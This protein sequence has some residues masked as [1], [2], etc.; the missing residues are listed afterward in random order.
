M[1][2]SK[3]IAMATDLLAAGRAEDV[4]RMVDPLLEPIASP[5]SADPGQVMLHALMARVHL[6]HR[7]NAEAALELLDPFDTPDVRSRLG[8]MARAEVTLWLGWAHAMRNLAGDRRAHEDAQAL[9]LLD[10]AEELFAG[11][12]SPSGRCWALLGKARAYF[13][14]D[15]YHLMRRVLAEAESVHAKT[16]DAQAARWLHDLSVPALRFQG[17]YDDAQS[18]VDALFDLADDWNDQRVRGH[19]YA[20]QAALCYDLGRNPSSIREAASTAETLLR[21]LDGGSDYPLLAAFHAHVGALLR[22]G[23][24]SEA[25]SLLDEAGDAVDSYPVGRAHLQTLRARLAMRRNDLDAAEALMEDLFDHAH[26]LPHG[27]Q[28]SHVALLRGE[29]LARREHYEEAQTWIQRASRNARE[30]GHRGN[31]LRTLLALAQTAVHRGDLSAADALLTQTE[32][33]A[34]YYSVLPH[35]LRRFS[36]IGDLACADDRLDDA[37]S[38]YEQALSAASLVGDAYRA[39]QLQRT[40]G[41]LGAATR[42]EDALLD[43]AASTFEHLGADPELSATRAVVREHAPSYQAGTSTAFEDAIGAALSRA[44]TSVEL[45]AEAWIQGVEMLAPDRW[46]G[47]YRAN[48]PPSRP[49]PD[50]DAAQHSA[51]ASWTCVHEHGPAPEDLSFPNPSDAQTHTGSVQWIRLRAHSTERFFLG[52]AVDD[53]DDA[54]WTE[55]LRR[56]RPWIPVVRLAFDR[57]LHR[58]KRAPAALPRPDVEA[59]IPLDGFVSESPAMAALAR[60]IRR[61]HMSHSPVLITGESGTGKTLVGRA[62]HVTSERSA[63]PFRHVRCTNMQQ[64]PIE[65][66]LFG[67]VAED[68]SLVP[69]AFHEADGGT[70]LL[71]DVGD[72]PQPVQAS[73]LRALDSHEIVPQGA[74]DAQP[75]DVRVLATTSQDLKQQAQTGAFRE[76]LYYRLA[77]IPLRVPPLR[78]RREDLPLLVRHFLRTLGP[79]DMP[80]AS[81]TNRALDV[82][83]HYDWPG[84]VRQLRNEI[85][86][87]LVFV[88]SEP[89]PTIDADLLSDSIVRESSSPQAGTAPR[90]SMNADDE[91]DTIFQSDRSLSDVLADTE[92]RIIERVLRDCNGQ[93]TASAEVLGL[94]RQGL[95]KKMKRLDIDAS[96]FQ[97][98]EEPAMT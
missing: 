51:D 39:A 67:R 64:E 82:L 3:T 47:V 44:S 74:E 9:S 43:A 65:A 53:P 15:E 35:A 34:D 83:L 13:A 92:K 52:V 38:A 98:D 89:A 14:I 55:A 10:E 33:Y 1:N 16:N 42:A 45:V 97:V 20:H 23:L 49:S 4:V 84:N 30:T 7:G 85:E 24:W 72:L 17:A 48:T 28:R 36:V 59:S 80:A 54:S 26:H 68:G 63:G 91:L 61:I 58:R 69:G 37:R 29:L 56:M 70:L 31:Q 86:R 81:I 41:E 73:L 8:D 76:D 88:G 96:A 87:A 90:P 12:P 60:Q 40:L 21:R 95:Y 62:V 75:V 46:I 71:E 57:A 22:Q 18:H 79:N 27:L 6:V 5:P 11:I 93:V 19:A 50:H 2:Y 66:G 77:V 32:E 78:K 94:T 25:A